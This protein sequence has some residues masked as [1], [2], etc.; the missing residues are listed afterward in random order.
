MFSFRVLVAFGLFT[1]A[2]LTGIM[3]AFG[4]ATILGPRP[5]ERLVSVRGAMLTRTGEPTDVTFFPPGIGPGMG[6]EVVLRIPGGM[7]G[8]MQMTTVTLSTDH[9]KWPERTYPQYGERS[10]GATIR[11]GAPPKPVTLHLSGLAVPRDV[12]L[13][14]ATVNLRF[15][16][17]G[18]RP[19]AAGDYFT[20]E[21]FEE[22]VEVWCK[23]GRGR[24]EPT[25]L[26][27]IDAYN[28]YTTGMVA[29]GALV[30]VTLLLRSD[31]KRTAPELPDMAKG[32]TA[33]RRT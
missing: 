23:L 26:G 31:K 1:V 12:A 14:Y 13:A 32:K 25:G 6:F 16:I 20:V 4:P 9:A 19:E 15:T 21:P 30:V 28:R 33:K 10:W 11:K 29:I 3:T 27:N 22:E 24:I 18:T 5:P 2:V 7:D 8:H 17:A